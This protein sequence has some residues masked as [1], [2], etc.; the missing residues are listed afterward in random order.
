MRLFRASGSCHLASHRRNPAP[1][2]KRQAEEG[3]VEVAPEYLSRWHALHDWVCSRPCAVEIP[4]ANALAMSM[5]TTHPR[6]QRDFPQLLSLIKSHALLHQCTRE[7]NDDKIVSTIEDY[8]AVYE[9]VADAL[10]EGLEVS[11]PPHI[12]RVVEAVRDLSKRKTQDRALPPGL[13]TGVSQRAVA[14]Y[15]RQNAS[16]ISRTARQAIDEGYLADGTPGQGK[17]STLSIGSREL[18]QGYVLPPPDALVEAIRNGINHVPSPEHVSTE[19]VLTEA[20]TL[21]E[22]PAF[23]AEC[24][25]KTPA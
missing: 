20:T 1:A 21:V 10:A 17:E 2:V 12:R 5:P 8:C 14:D 3:R 18:P 24:R 16:S 9:L 11:V 15:L 13:W 25:E 23:E 22:T 4:Y 7:R 19:D 6:V